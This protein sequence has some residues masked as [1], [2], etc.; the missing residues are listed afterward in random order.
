[1]LYGAGSSAWS[2]TFTPTYQINQYFVRVE[3]SYVKASN[4]TGGLAF[5]YSG[6]NNSQARAMME[7]GI[8]Y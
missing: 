1:M 5:G 4:T 8:L 2:F 3:A 7:V 6:N